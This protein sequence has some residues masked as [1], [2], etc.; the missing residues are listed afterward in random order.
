M[1]AVTETAR[2]QSAATADIYGQNGVEQYEWL[3]EDNACT[4]GKTTIGCRSLADN[5]PYD[6][7]PD[8]SGDNEEQPSQPWH[9]NCR[10]TYLPVV[11]DANG[12]N[13]A[14]TSD[15]GAQAE[16]SDLNATNVTNESDLPQSEEEAA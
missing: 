10:C 2:A 11:L 4:D 12:E 13:I 5:G 3:A 8:P 14:P 7:P 6:M 1:I 15:E 9:P 16:G